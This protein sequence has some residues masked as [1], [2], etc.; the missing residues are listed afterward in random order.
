ME[1]GGDGDGA[2]IRVSSVAGLEP[3]NSI[4]LRTTAGYVEESWGQPRYE[5]AR[6]DPETLTIYLCDSLEA[7]PVPDD[8]VWCMGKNDVSPKDIFRLCKG[9]AED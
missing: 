7:K 2:Q 9:T 6:V 5:V 4:S 3:G 1:L 8:L